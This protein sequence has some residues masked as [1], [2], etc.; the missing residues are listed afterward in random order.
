MLLRK[1]KDLEGQIILLNSVENVMG[2]HFKKNW[3]NADSFLFCD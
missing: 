1:N 2:Y 3:L